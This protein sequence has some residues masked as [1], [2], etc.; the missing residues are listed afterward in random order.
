MHGPLRESL[1]TATIKGDNNDDVAM[2][3][4]VGVIG[5]SDS[6]SAEPRW[7]GAD[8]CPEITSPCGACSVHLRSYQ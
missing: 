3:G 5:T 2:Q 6:R 1:P 4:P 8:V 7:K